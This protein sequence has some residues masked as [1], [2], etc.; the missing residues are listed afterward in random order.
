M[1]SLDTVDA[2]VGHLCR[3]GDRHVARG[4]DAAALACLVEAWELLPEPREEC[5]A[6]ADVFRGFTRVLRGRSGLEAL[7]ARRARFRAVLD[8]LG[9]GGEPE[10]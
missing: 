4:E 5:P 2:R 6:T 8:S 1:R 10:A 3:E 7:L 9:L